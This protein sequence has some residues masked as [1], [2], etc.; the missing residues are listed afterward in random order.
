MN[1]YDRGQG[2][3]PSFSPIGTPDFLSSL[4]HMGDNLVHSDVKCSTAQPADGQIKQPRT[5]L[6]GQMVNNH[7]RLTTDG[8]SVHPRTP[9]DGQMCS[10][11]R[12][13]LDGQ[14]IHPRTPLDGGQLGAS[15]G[16]LRTPLDGQLMHPRTPMDGHMMSHPRTPMDGQLVNPRTPVDGSQ[17]GGCPRT[18]VDNHHFHVGDSNCQATSDVSSLRPMPGT[19]GSNP[20]TPAGNGNRAYPVTAAGSIAASACSSRSA[21]IASCGGNSVTSCSSGGS[22][23]VAVNNNNNINSICSNDPGQQQSVRSN[24]GNILNTDFAF[25]DSDGQSH[26][27]LDVS[28]ASY[29]FKVSI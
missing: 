4:T 12:T 17:M 27:T 6:D 23:A 20:R 2:P 18:P 24:S 3:S 7:M 22:V 15:T 8:Q 14:L 25:V 28:T 10:N 16:Q 11:P 1:C 9:L 19:P 29:F 21:S 5:P 26:E 13:P